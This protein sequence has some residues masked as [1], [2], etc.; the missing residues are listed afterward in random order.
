M[1]I[2]SKIPDDKEK[3]LYFTPLQ[4]PHTSKYN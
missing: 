3:Y 4:Y 2:K 1:S